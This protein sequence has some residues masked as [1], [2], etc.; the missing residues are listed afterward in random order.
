MS[1]S[2]STNSSIR[3]KR[4]HPNSS[5]EE[6]ISSTKSPSPPVKKQKQQHTTNLMDKEIRNRYPN[7]SS[8][9]AFMSS[10]S[11]KKLVIKNL[12]S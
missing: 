9:S 1:K 5:I 8:S 12:K 11:T 4:D 10:N 6:P 3:L 2:N 7:G